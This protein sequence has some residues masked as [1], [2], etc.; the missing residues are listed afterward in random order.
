MADKAISDLVAASEV[1]GTDLFVLE[2]AG[3]AKK[4][5]GQTL[6]TFLLKLVEAH[7]GISSIAKTGTSGL[8][9]TYT[10]TMADETKSSFTVTNGE[11]G[12]KG[13]NT[14]TWLKYSSSLPTKNSDMYDT[15]D[16][17]MGIYT[18]SSSTAPSS[19]SAYKWF[20]IKGEKGDT[21][22]AAT[23]LTQSVCY[24]VSASGS[25]VP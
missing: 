13:D 24:Q 18:G 10:I 5:S 21:G 1:V 4:L 11:K 12:D 17:Y 6:T 7:G 22:D 19:Y 20:Q 8:V 2:Q 16:N 9:D 14:Y 15:P 25:V 23:L 3:T